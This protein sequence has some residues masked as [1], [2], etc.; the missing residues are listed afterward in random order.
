MQFFLDEMFENVLVYLK[1]FEYASFELCLGLALSSWNGSVDRPKGQYWS[2]GVGIFYA[3]HYSPEK[4]VHLFR[5][6]LN[7]L[8]YRQLIPRYL[9]ATKKLPVAT[10]WLDFLLNHLL[11]Y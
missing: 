4:V 2:I 11:L 9:V 3:T 7:F 8:Q 10:I 5:L 6:T 1:N